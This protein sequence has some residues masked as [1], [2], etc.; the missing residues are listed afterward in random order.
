MSH[1][2]SDR[3]SRKRRRHT[4]KK[5]FDH[6][7]IFPRSAPLS[8]GLEGEGSRPAILKV[9]SSLKE[10]RGTERYLDNHGRDPKVHNTSRRGQHDIDIQKE[11]GSPT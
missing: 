11:E 3:R 4:T 2:K 8:N 1:I 9:G 6:Q 10:R 5:H 7:R